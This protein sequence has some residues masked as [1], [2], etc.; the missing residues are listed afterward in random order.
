MVEIDSC[1]QVFARFPVH[2][3]P[4]R[5]V[6]CT[7]PRLVTFDFRNDNAVFDVLFLYGGIKWLSITALPK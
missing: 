3:Q 6:L 7:W 2:G 5:S 1:G 4:P